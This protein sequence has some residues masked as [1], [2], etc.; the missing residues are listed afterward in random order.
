MRNI[1][2]EDLNIATAFYKKELAK[3]QQAFLNYQSSSCY[4]LRAVSSLSAKAKFFQHQ[5]YNCNPMLKHLETY[6]VEIVEDEDWGDSDYD[7]TYND[8]VAGSDA[9]EKYTE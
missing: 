5:L 6:C 1:L 8:V 4:D 9:K 7:N 2:Q 3:I